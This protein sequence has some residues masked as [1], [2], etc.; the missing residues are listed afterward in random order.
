M[1]IVE[2]ISIFTTNLATL[3]NLAVIVPN[4]QITGG[5]ITNFSAKDTRRVDMT[6]EIAYD[7][8]ISAAKEAIWDC[9]E[10]R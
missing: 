9:V 3:D 4:A 2:E 1:G 5:S 7:D 6:S 8:N 10:S